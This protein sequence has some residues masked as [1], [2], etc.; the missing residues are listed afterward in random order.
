M[1]RL[2]LEDAGYEV[3][4]VENGA[5]GLAAYRQQPSALVMTDIIMP[6]MEGFATL[7]E[8]LRLDP[9]VKIIAMTAA[10][11]RVAAYLDTAQ[12]FGAVGVLKKPF[13]RSELLLAVSAA[14]GKDQMPER[15]E[16]N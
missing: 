8:L 3:Q 5:I 6:V 9:S 7:I 10:H 12:I 11:E 14:L 4:D 2:I 1:S 16:H 13:T 15:E